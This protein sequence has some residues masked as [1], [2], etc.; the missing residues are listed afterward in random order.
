M[1]KGQEKR[2]IVAFR[3]IGIVHSPLKKKQDVSPE[4][5]R[6]KSGFSNVQGELEIYP[7][8]GKGLQDTEG[9]SHLIV[10]FHFHRSKE[11]SLLAHPPFESGERGVFATRSPNRPNAIGMTVVTLIKKEG[12][13]LF[14]SGL[15][16]LDGTPILDLKP[17]T[18][19]DI[20]PDAQFGWIAQ[21]PGLP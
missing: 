18:S 8:Y 19:R 14:V 15:D 6:G 13:R 7:E 16:I 2:M 9:F 5:Y 10:L 20:H 17:Y 12:N 1:T 3:H 21:N 4:R 11:S